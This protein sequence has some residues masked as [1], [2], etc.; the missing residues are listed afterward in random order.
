MSGS[1]AAVKESAIRGENLRTK[2]KICGLTRECDIDFVNEALPDY[3]G[4]VFAKSRRQVNREQAQHLRKRLRPAVKTV[5]VFV[6]EP[7]EQLVRL[8]KEGILDMVQLHGSETPEFVEKIKHRLDCPVIKAVRLEEQSYPASFFRSY[9]QAGVDVFLFDSGAVWEENADARYGGTGRPFDWQLLPKTECP[10]FLAGGL[11]TENIEKA[12]LLTRPY[13]VDVSSGVET[14][15][16]K[17]K[18]KILEIVRR[19]RNV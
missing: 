5:G 3:V 6:N 10:C 16:V 9:E 4:F 17:D 7:E 14:D 13:A 8:A 12:I 19:V 2:I 18:D 11:N 1:E 15:G